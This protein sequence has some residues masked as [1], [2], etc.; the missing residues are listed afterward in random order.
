MSEQVNEGE[1]ELIN[2]SCLT[3]T[4]DLTRAVEVNTVNLPLSALSEI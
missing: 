3:L 1:N 2:G 4:I